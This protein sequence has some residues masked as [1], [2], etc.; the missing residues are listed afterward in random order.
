[1]AAS[2]RM[3]PA[4]RRPEQRLNRRG[5]DR[6]QEPGDGDHCP[7]WAMPRGG[8]LRHRCTCSVDTHVSMPWRDSLAPQYPRARQW[9]TEAASPDRMSEYSRSRCRCRRPPERWV[10]NVGWCRTPAKTRLPGLGTKVHAWPPT[11]APACPTDAYP[12]LPPRSFGGFA[13]RTEGCNT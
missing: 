2:W 9:M 5:F 8:P 10:G 7:V 1:P 3:L 6:P 4:S 11:L 12:T 13:A